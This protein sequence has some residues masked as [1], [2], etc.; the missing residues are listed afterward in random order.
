MISLQQLDWN[1][2]DPWNLQVDSKTK[3]WFSNKDRSL[4]EFENSLIKIRL[5]FLITRP[6]KVERL[7]GNAV[8]LKKDNM[9]YPDQLW[10][11]KHII[12]WW[13]NKIHQNYK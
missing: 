4:I 13:F 5:I 11:N 1:G 6:W 3:K 10:V 8:D 2:H 9:Q 7:G 12:K